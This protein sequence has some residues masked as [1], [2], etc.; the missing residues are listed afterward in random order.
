MLS[1]A[2][3]TKTVKLPISSQK[4]A[5]ALTCFIL[6]SF[7]ILGMLGPTLHINNT[8]F[9]Y[10]HNPT[11]DRWDERSLSLS[12]IMEAYT[13]LSRVRLP[14][15]T[16]NQVIYSRI[17]HHVED[18]LSHQASQNIAKRLF[19]LQ[20]LYAAVVA[21]VQDRRRGYFSSVRSW[22]RYR[23]L[24]VPSSLTSQTKADASSIFG[25]PITMLLPKWRSKWPRTPWKAF[26][27]SNALPR[28]RDVYFATH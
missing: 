16:R 8:Y 25:S 13:E 23:R 4:V 11:S 21:Q 15:A 26:N 1:N 5:P 3:W 9:T 10:I 27:P 24:N 14:W 12:R 6:V 22:V 7:E 17:L 18:I 20:E 19:L 28:L 2:S